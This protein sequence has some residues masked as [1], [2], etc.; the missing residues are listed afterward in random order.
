MRVRKL[1]HKFRKCIKT[2]IILTDIKNSAYIMT[3]TE[4]YGIL[5]RYYFLLFQPIE[6]R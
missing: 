6:I 5:M 3:I 4:G 1:D 2:V